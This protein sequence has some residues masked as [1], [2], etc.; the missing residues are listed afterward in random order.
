M[1]QISIEQLIYCFF[2]TNSRVPSVDVSNTIQFRSG[3]NIKTLSINATASSGSF[4]KTNDG[5]VS[6]GFQ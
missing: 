3:K 6:F 1:S 4:T 2:Q 5:G